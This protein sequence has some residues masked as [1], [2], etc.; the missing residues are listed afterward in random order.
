T[1]AAAQVVTGDFESARPVAEQAV[2]AA[3]D[4]GAPGREATARMMLGIALAYLGDSE[5]GV[6][7][8]E[9]A[10]ALAEAAGDHPI[11]LRAHLNLSDV[12]QSLGRSHDAA[13]VAERGMELAGRGGLPR[14]G[15]RPSVSGH[16]APAPSPPA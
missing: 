15:H 7:E 10:V 9:A 14:A 11:T 2:A 16:R 8:L 13:A 3:H 6:A 12:L 4:A 5:Q 1:L